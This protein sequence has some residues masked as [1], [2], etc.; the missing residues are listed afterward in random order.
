MSLC[1]RMC[2]AVPQNTVSLESVDATSARLQILVDNMRSTATTMNE[3]SQ[4]TTGY[5][6]VNEYTAG[7]LAFLVAVFLVFKDKIYQYVIL[8]DVYVW[9]AIPVFDVVLSVRTTQCIQRAPLLI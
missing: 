1:T 4:R 6:L 9:P 2:F 3:Y 7:L 8:R 5:T